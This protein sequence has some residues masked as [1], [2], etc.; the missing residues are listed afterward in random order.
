MNV[1]R[2]GDALAQLMAVERPS[3]VGSCR[4][5]ADETAPPEHRR[6]PAIRYICRPLFRRGLPLE[7]L[8]EH[9]IAFSGLK[10]GTHEFTFELGQTFFQA[11]AEEAFAGGRVTASVRMDKSPAMLVVNMHVEGPVSVHCDRCDAPLEVVLHGDQRQIFKLSDDEDLDDD[12]LVAIG[13]HAH[14]VNLTHYLYE[15]VRL[16]LPARNVHAPGQCDP[17]V[18]AVL[19]RHIVDHEPA[20][21]PR[22]DALK[23]LQNK[24]P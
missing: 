1:A 8:H 16:A 12:E 7:P 19:A 6:I 14:D 3:T 4:G 10:D 23:E 24:R 22:W 11:T 17:E 18:E 20:P 15:C 21:D 13:S 2:P 5:P 9:T